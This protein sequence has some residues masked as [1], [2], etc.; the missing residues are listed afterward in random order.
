[1]RQL[2]LNLARNL[3]FEINQECNL[4]SVHPLC[5]SG[6]PI[7]YKYGKQE[8]TITD[9]LMIE[10]WLWCRDKHYFRGIWNFCGH[11]EPTLV[12]ERI[13]NLLVR[14]RT[15]DPGL[16]AQLV[17]NK[18]NFVDQWDDFDIIKRSRYR[19]GGVRLCDDRRPSFD[20]RL[21]AALGGEGKPYAQMSPWGRC[22]RGA[23][24]EILVDVWGNWC[25]CCADF[26]CELAFGNLWTDNW[27]EMFKM[28]SERYRSMKWHDEAS[29]NALPRLCRACLDV[30]P[31]LHLREDLDIIRGWRD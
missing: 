19:E 20:G 8:K 26:S 16:P 24:W 28:A 18:E 29:Y 2:E 7:R 22:I 21:A 23:G 25:N 30:N 14:A 15:I 6:N 3:S 4:A 17:T 12:I 13:H 5:P 1:M 9:D 10:F 27:E 11:N 31:T